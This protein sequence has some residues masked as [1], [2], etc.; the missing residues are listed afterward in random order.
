ML[1]K[2]TKVN[3]IYNGEHK[4]EDTYLKEIKLR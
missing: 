4:I 1:K 3:F 2:V